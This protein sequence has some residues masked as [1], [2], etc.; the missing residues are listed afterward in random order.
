M[1]QTILTDMSVTV[2]EVVWANFVKIR[3]PPDNRN[4][5]MATSIND[6][7]AEI[8]SIEK[9]RKIWPYIFNQPFKFPPRF[10]VVNGIE[11]ICRFFPWGHFEFIEINTFGTSRWRNKILFIRGLDRKSVV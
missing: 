6:A 7:V 4:I 8:D 2:E 11:G 3:H 10:D 5:I 1:L 9:K